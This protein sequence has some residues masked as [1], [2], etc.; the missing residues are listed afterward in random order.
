MEDKSLLLDTSHHSNASQFGK[1]LFRLNFELGP[2]K[3][4]KINV[5]DGDNFY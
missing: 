4:A 1:L 2:G 3:S 5:K